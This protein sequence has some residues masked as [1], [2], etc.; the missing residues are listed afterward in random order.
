MVS[1]GMGAGYKKSIEILEVSDIEGGWKYGTP[2]PL[3]IWMHNMVSWEDRVYI[4]G[5][6][7]TYDVR[8]SILQYKSGVWQE[9]ESTLKVGR[10]QT[11]TIPISDE[12]ADEFCYCKKPEDGDPNFKYAGTRYNMNY[13]RCTR[14]NAGNIVSEREKWGKK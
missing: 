1:G 12:Q 14:F 11:L 8:K 6:V 7:D 10:A 2:L 5:G 3:N 13:H 9:I 4:V